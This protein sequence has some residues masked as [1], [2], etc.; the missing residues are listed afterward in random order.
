MLSD[1][2]IAI[3]F[4]FLTS[5]CGFFDLVRRFPFSFRA[6]ENLVSMKLFVPGQWINFCWPP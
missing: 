5:D 1:G 6:T 4:G 3:F 2:K